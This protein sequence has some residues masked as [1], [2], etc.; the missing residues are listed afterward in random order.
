MADEEKIGLAKVLENHATLL[1]RLQATQNSLKEDVKEVDHDL[2]E[3]VT[4]D[5]LGPIDDVDS[6]LS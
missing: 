4:E 6:A 2:E 3:Y 1:R 5:E